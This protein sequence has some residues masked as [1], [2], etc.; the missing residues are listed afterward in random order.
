MKRLLVTGASGLLGLNLAVEA[1]NSYDVT[2]VVHRQPLTD[3]PFQIR[4]LDLNH[5]RYRRSRT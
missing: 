3:T 2:A 5:D 1:S 4:V